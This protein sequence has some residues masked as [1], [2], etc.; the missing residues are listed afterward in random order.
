MNPFTRCSKYDQYSLELSGNKNSRQ[1]AFNGFNGFF[2][3]SIAYNFFSR[4]NSLSLASWSCPPTKQ[5]DVVLVS[6]RNMIQCASRV[7]ADRYS[8]K[9]VLKAY[10]WSYLWLLVCLTSRDNMQW[11][12]TSL[13]FLALDF[14]SEWEFALELL[15]FQ[16]KMSWAVCFNNNNNNGFFITRT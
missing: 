10:L 16:E 1:Q 3:K 2:H 7:W 12:F 6:T 13:F 9:I 8:V 4:Y 14:F 11:K 5:L 15:L